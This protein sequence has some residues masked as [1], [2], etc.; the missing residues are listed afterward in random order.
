MV[1]KVT[2]IQLK[3]E[4]ISDTT[5]MT[6]KIYHVFPLVARGGNIK[7]FSLHVCACIRPQFFC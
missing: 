6:L 7:A 3:S 5:D 2:I 4:V 1:L